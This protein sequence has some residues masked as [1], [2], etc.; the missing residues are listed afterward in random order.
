MRMSSAVSIAAVLLAAS[1]SL[2]FWAWFALPP[3]AGVPIHGLDLSGEFHRTASREAVF[4]VPWATLIVLTILVLISRRGASEAAPEAMDAAFIG[5]SG[6]L[7][8]AQATLVWSA[9]HPDFEPVR[10]IALAVAVLL[11]A[12]GNVL[13]KARRN[14]LVGIRTP[15]A[16]ADA[17]VWDKTQRFG[18]RAMM[19]GGLVLIG[20]ALLF[21]D[22]LAL[23][24]SIAAC[25]ALPMI[26]A[27]VW[28]RRLSQKT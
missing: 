8:T 18:G 20:L 22:P 26:V 13:G 23:A 6:V 7:L 11:L 5:V 17:N 27:V 15:W 10:P 12:L 28:S 21:G 2:A 4:V 14:F 25:A 24:L 16:L 19:L 1:T 9:L 3:G